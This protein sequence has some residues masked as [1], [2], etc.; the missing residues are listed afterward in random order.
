M[1]DFVN[2]IAEKERLQKALN[3]DSAAFIVLYGRRRCGKS[4]LI[5]QVLSS[6]DCYFMADR[7][8]ATQQRRLLSKELAKI[9]HGFDNVVYHNWDILFDNLNQRLKKKITLCLDEFPYLVKSAPELPSIIQKWIDRKD[10]LQFNLIIC[11]SS[12]QMMHSL[13][14]DSAEP[15]YGRADE[16]IKLQPLALPFIADVLKCNPIEAVEEYSVWGG[17]PRYWELRKTQN[18]LFEAVTHH[19]LSSQGVLYDEPIRLFL[20]DM[21]DTVHS[22]TIL[23]LVAAGCNR[24]SELAARLEKPST[25]L[26]NPLDRLLS[27]GYLERVIPFGENP[28]NTKKTLYKIADPFLRFYFQF[29][30]PNKSNI[31]LDNTDFIL[32]EIKAAF[33]KFVSFQWEKLCR[34]AVP[35]MEINGA[36][37]STASS[38]WGTPVKNKSIE[39][40]VVAE[41]RCGK[42]L[43]TGECKW[44]DK[45]PDIQQLI[46]E[47]KEKSLLLPFA[48]DKTVLPVLF[49][50]NKQ[51][52][53]ADTITIFYPEDILS[54]RK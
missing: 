13:V 40:D 7:S 33:D 10:E 30:V 18:S 36:R 35:L 52:A 44:W 25:N 17:I 41:S 19:I 42:Y 47:L 26:A 51:P 4:R 16:I 27:L 8:E 43:L 38:Y 21:R 24:L 48:K 28:R 49:L 6:E 32:E 2:R 1:L 46:D 39:I 14:F 23:S 31:E 15:L 9:I 29:V 37:F 50:K 20:D 3:Q 34:A 45:K 11:G 54:I 5:K 22:F 53:P 12:Q